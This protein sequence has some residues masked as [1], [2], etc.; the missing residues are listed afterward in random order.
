M[1]K[2]QREFYDKQR[3]RDQEADRNHAAAAEIFADLMEEVRTNA[4]KAANAGGKMDLQKIFR[5][6]DVDGSGTID[7]NEFGRA[8][9]QMGVDLPGEELALVF[10]FL[11]RDGAGVDYGEFQLAFF[12]RASLAKQ[13]RPKIQERSAAHH[14]MLKMESLVKDSAIVEDTLRLLDSSSNSNPE[15]WHVRQTSG[16]QNLKDGRFEQSVRDFTYAILDLMS[17]LDECPTHLGLSM[18]YAHR[19][20]AFDGLADYL[21]AFDDASQSV[22]WAPGSY[23]SHLALGDACFRLRRYLDAAGHYKRGLRVKPKHPVLVAKLD[24]AQ[25]HGKAV[26]YGIHE[27]PGL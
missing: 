24:K 19:S 15:K 3:K 16:L 14:W 12:N 13:P 7:L 17:R 20:R 11:D 21:S 5:R 23:K 1:A 26:Q 4:L 6:I 27:A 8:L 18:L 9:M 2:A 22:E 10:Q 25:Y